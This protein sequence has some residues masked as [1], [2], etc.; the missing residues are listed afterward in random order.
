[1]RIAGAI[2]Q[3]SHALALVTGDSLGQVASQTLEN[4]TCVDDA[5]PLP[6]LR[7]LIGMDKQEIIGAA[8]GI[9]TYETSILPYADCCSL[10]VPRSPATKASVEECRRAEEGLDVDALVSGCLERTEVVRA[11]RVAAENVA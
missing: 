7:P 6:I 2:A 5:S 3:R 4:M 9:G 8:Q 1:V 11:E 10:F